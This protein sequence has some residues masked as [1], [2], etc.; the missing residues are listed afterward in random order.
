[1]LDMVYIRKQD[2]YDSAYMEYTGYMVLLA[3]KLQMN[4]HAPAS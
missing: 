2:S 1:M 4:T 3:R